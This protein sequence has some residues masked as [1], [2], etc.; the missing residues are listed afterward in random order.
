VR[1][2]RERL[3]R[4]EP[5]V[6]RVHLVAQ[7]IEP[8]EEGVELAVVQVFPVLGHGPDFSRGCVPRA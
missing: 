4:V 3:G 6:Q 5:P 8:L 7:T 1:D 2:P